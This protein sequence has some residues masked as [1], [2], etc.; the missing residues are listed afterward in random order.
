[1]VCYYLKKIVLIFPVEYTPF[2]IIKFESAYYV[3]CFPKYSPCANAGL[4][5]A[6][7][8]SIKQK[9]LVP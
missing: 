7:Q 2:K 8:K 6:S 5:L 4:L 3:L 9:R 1:M